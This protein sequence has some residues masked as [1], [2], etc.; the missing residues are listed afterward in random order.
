M[1]QVA[2]DS[3]AARLQVAKG[4]L[5]QAVTPGGAADK[6][7]LL[8]TRRGL[9]GILT[10]DVILQVLPLLGA[11]RGIVPGPQPEAPCA[12]LWPSV[13]LSAGESYV[14]QHRAGPG[15]RAGPAQRGR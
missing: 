3:V 5:I 9:T 4:A 12:L 7:G 1:W 13:L 8:P 14:H 10:G 6:A 11:L 15:Q 2:T